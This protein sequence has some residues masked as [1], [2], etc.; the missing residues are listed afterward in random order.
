MLNKNSIKIVYDLSVVQCTISP[1]LI[2]DFRVAP[3]F[4]IETL[5]YGFTQIC[6][7]SIIS[8]IDSSFVVPG[9]INECNN[10]LTAIVVFL[11]QVHSCCAV[12]ALEVS[13]QAHSIV[14]TSRQHVVSTRAHASPDQDLRRASPRRAGT[15]GRASE[16]GER[17]RVLEQGSSY[18][19][20]SRRYRR[21]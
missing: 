2:A 20:T 17:R 18:G 12:I 13:L 11:H 1:S 14:V 9:S 5:V 6:K 16:E 21:L 10:N 4:P 15:R 3:T 8:G 19:G 7:A